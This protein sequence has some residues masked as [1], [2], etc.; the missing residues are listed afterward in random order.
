MYRFLYGH[1]YLYLYPYPIHIDI[2]VHM[3]VD[4]Q[5]GIHIFSISTFTS[6]SCIYVY[7]HTH[8]HT[9]SGHLSSLAKVGFDGRGLVAIITNVLG[10]SGAVGSQFHPEA[11]QPEIPGHPSPRPLGQG[12]SGGRGPTVEV[13]GLSAERVGSQLAG[14]GIFHEGSQL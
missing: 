2:Y 5:I 7:T 9:S 13:P 12:L 1:L 3:H 10:H 4:I 8:T 6:V 11:A 14:F